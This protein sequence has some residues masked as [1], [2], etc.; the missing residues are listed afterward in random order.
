[1]VSGR[2]FVVL[3]LTE[4]VWDSPVVCLSMAEMSVILVSFR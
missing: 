4:L 3:S 1:M 2:G